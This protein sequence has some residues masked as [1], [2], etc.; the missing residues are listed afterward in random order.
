MTESGQVHSAAQLIKGFIHHTPVIT[1]NYFDTV[2]GAKIFF[3]CE[4]LQRIGAFKI[5]GAI[6]ALRR[7]DKKILKHG[8]ITHSSGNHGQ[9]V[10]LA[11]KLHGINATIVMPR[12]TSKIKIEA[13]QGY[14]G[15]VVFCE[16]GTLPREQ[17]VAEITAQSGAAFIHPYNDEHV[18]AGQGTAAA[19]CL[20]Q[21][22]GLDT[23]LT[24]V[25]GGGLIS[26]T[27]LAVQ[28]HGSTTQVI[29]AEPE[30]ANDAAQS[31]AAHRIIA[32]ASPVNSIA[33]GLRTNSI[34]E[35][36][37]A[38]IDKHV[39]RIL[40]VTEDEIVAA[41]R[42]IWE[43]MKLI[44]EPSSAVPVAALLRYRNDFA[45]RRIGIILS[46]GNV[47]LNRLPWQK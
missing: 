44:V 45:G 22:E 39:H 43:R 3:K 40:L 4:N 14:G 2:V 17:K 34:G 32:V 30:Q 18:I 1:S 47:D 20:R 31:L 28:E 27:C 9:A 10:A 12:D 8:V 35:L 16:P 6:N 36:N 13:V 33:D 23:L 24:P 38:I 26:G 46:G 21:V 41:M 42:Q 25:G 37:F 11:A 15:N 29:G 7:I 5:R 19:E